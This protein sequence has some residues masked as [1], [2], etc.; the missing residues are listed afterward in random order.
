MPARKE[1][2]PK[3]THLMYCRFFPNTYLLELSKKKTNESHNT[4][5]NGRCGLLGSVCH[6][7]VDALLRSPKL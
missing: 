2:I 6:P 1:C 5:N 3:G 4:Q 7:L